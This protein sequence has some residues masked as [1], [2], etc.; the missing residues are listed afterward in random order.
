MVGITEGY[1][2]KM[3]KIDKIKHHLKDRINLFEHI[4]NTVRS[5]EKFSINDVQGFL[6]DECTMLLQYMDHY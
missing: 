6:I 4:K 3:S 1:D 2:R 5:E